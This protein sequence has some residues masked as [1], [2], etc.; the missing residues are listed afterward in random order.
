MQN[1]SGCKSSLNENKKVVNKIRRHPELDSGSS[2]HAVSQ[3]QQPAWKIPNQVWNDTNLITA[4]QHGGFT[5]IELLV[6]VLIIGILAAVA[7]PQYRKAV[8]KSRFIEVIS[9]VDNIVREQEVHYL[10]T[11]AYAADLEELAVEQ[12]NFA[13]IHGVSDSGTGIDNTPAVVGRIGDSTYGLGYVRYLEHGKNARAAGHRYC[14]VG[15]MGGD[16]EKI[17]H[18][19]CASLTGKSVKSST[20][21]Y[22]TDYDFN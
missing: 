4:K 1:K 16:R 6:V 15:V 13:D 2:T 3:G 17:S 10:A 8:I 12:P 20:N 22:Y 9:A 7:L 18:Q 5:L 14:R 19:I 11:G 21:G